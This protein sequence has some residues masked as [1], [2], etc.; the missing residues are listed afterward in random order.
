MLYLK[1]FHIGDVLQQNSTFI[2]YQE[3][4]QP[5]TDTDQQQQ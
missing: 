1:L 5:N 2:Q 4:K 3:V